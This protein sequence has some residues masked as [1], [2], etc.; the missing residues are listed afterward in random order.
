MDD[1]DIKRLANKGASVA[2]NPCSNLR[3]GNGI[4]PVHEMQA[5]GINIGIGT[6]GSH[7]SDHQNILKIFG[8]L[9]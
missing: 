2:H 5:A 1:D 8:W 6:D 3:L 9:L 7:C 4:A